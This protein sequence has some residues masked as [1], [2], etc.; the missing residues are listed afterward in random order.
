M[1]NILIE[2]LPGRIAYQDLK[3]ASLEDFTYNFVGGV[4]VIHVSRQF[5]KYDD[6]FWGETE[7][8][9]ARAKGSSKK[10]IKGLAD[11]RRKGIDPTAKLPA[12]QETV[13]TDIEGKTYHYKAENGITRKKSD[14]L[15]GYTEGAWFD[16]VRYVETEGRSAEYNR[17]VWLHIENDPLPSEGNSIDDLVQSCS[18]MICSGDLPKEESSIRDFVYESAPNMPTQ[19]KNE[20]VRIV[21]K[22]EKVPTRTIS[23]RDNE[24][25]EWL[26]EK[27]LDEVKV[28]YCFP[29]HYFQDRVYSVLKQYHNTK[30]VQYVVQHFDNKGDSD[31]VIK[32]ARITQKEKWE[33]FREVMKSVALYMVANDWQLPVDKDQYFPQILTGDNKEDTNRI[34]FD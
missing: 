9:P 21:L 25:R 2:T 19:D 27:C 11:S 1:Q 12:V 23:W 32:A 7:E 15:N 30:E 5:I 20:V 31:E 33:E 3:N 17:R 24:C 22:E 4:G 13:I 14:Y 29:F 8:N 18:E 34:V 16:V 26:D 6:I 28:D 10:N